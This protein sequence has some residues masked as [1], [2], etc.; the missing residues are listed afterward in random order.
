VIEVKKAAVVV[1]AFA[2]LMM[3]AAVA[4]VMAMGPLKAQDVGHNPNLSGAPG[5][6]IAHLDGGKSGNT[7]MFINAGPWEGMIFHDCKTTTGNGRMNNAIVVTIAV[8][9]DFT[10]HPELYY[11]EW[12][13]FSGDNSGSQ[14]NNPIDDPDVGPHGM[15]YWFAE[16][17]FGAGYGPAVV[18]EHPDGVFVNWHFVGN[19]P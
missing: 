7:F 18:A 13:F 19:A 1:L 11:N 17:A 2:L 12:M 3:F 16:K 14:F 9:M 5:S 15:L 6:G 10:V 8:M 4:P